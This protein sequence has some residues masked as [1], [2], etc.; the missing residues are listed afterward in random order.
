MKIQER[1]QRKPLEEPV[2][3]QETPRESMNVGVV[4]P[5]SQTLD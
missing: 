1:T 2:G 5:E 3:H 4:F